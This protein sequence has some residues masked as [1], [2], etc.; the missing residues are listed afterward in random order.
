M[1]SSIYIFFWWGILVYMWERD[2]GVI[3]KAQGD[4][5]YTEQETVTLSGHTA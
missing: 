5:E 4:C 3:E 1:K 2:D